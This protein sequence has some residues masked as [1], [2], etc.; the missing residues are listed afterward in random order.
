MVWCDVEREREREE[1]EEEEDEDEDEDEDDDEEDDELV[2]KG[3][4]RGTSVACARRCLQ[5][6]TFGHTC[7]N[8][9][10]N[11]INGYCARSVLLNLVIKPLCVFTE[12]DV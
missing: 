2:R 8:T 11:R 4:E 5:T 3:R 6:I 9:R 10:R 1:E 12:R 7:I